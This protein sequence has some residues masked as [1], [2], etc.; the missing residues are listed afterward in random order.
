MNQ[1]IVL[2]M[3][4][5]LRYQIFASK[6]NQAFAY[7]SRNEIKQFMFKC[8][9]WEREREKEKWG[10]FQH[11]SHNH[12]CIIM[13]TKLGNILRWHAYR[14]SFNMCTKNGDIYVYFLC[15]NTHTNTH[16]R[17]CSTTTTT[18]N[19]SSATHHLHSRIMLKRKNWWIINY[20]VVLLRL[21]DHDSLNCLAPLPN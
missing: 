16:N 20:R 8:I 2:W 3:N 7:K 4:Q 15:A 10:Q 14:M 11:L 5:N 12:I 21:Q 13:Y 9:V 19:S 18:T 17:P 6:L 1:R